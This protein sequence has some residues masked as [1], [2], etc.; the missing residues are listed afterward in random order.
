MPSPDFNL[1]VREGPEKGH[2]HEMKQD[3]LV[4]GS[5]P[6]SD[7]IFEVSSVD[8]QHARLIFDGDRLILEDLGSQNGTFR[9]GTRL[10]GPLQVFPG[11]Q[12]GLG[13]DVII[14]LEG[15]DP[16]ELE[17]EEESDL[18][19]GYASNVTDGAAEP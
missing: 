12:I 10:L 18:N 6:P 1:R 17:T 19:L 8:P 7:V 11:D 5:K 9:N 13:P 16:R 3:V 15:D 14:T 2:K 4:L